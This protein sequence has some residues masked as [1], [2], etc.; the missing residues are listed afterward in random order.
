[1]SVAFPT[2]VIPALTGKANGYNADEFLSLTASQASWFASI[3]FICQPLGSIMSGW[4]S[5]P[6]GRK[7]AMFLVNIPHVIAWVMMYNA[8]TIEEVFAANVLLGL[9]VGL[10]EA[11]IIT[12]VGEIR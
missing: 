3:A 7:R 9:G 1:M 2:I 4:I 8:S 6:L 10:M 11:P 12:Y 5:E